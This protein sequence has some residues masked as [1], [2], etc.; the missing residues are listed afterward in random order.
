MN[1]R[2]IFAWLVVAIIIATCMFFLY[3]I[4]DVNSAPVRYSDSKSFHESSVVPKNTYHDTPNLQK[5]HEDHLLFHSEPIHP[6]MESPNEMPVVVGQ[7]EEDLRAL[8]QVSD[9]PPSIE[10]PIPE[11]KDPLE[12]VVN[13]ESEFGDNLRHPEQTIEIMPPMGS[14]RVMPSGMG[15][16]TPPSLGGHTSVQYTPELAQNGGEFMSGIFAFDT[17]DGGGIGFSMI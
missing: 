10:Y 3:H 2:T 6:P 13:S 8:R 12:T 4:V 11:A 7:S 9:T 1:P 16:E 5:Q 17:S 14:M 15:S